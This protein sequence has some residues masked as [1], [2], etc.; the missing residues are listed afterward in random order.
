LSVVANAAAAADQFT[1]LTVREIAKAPSARLSPDRSKGWLRRSLPLVWAHKLTLGF[2]LGLST[3]SVALQA[4]LLLISRHTIDYAI[5]LRTASLE[6]WV[7]LLVLVA[8]L[9]FIVSLLGRQLLFVTGFG[10][11]YDLRSIVFEHLQRLPYEFHVR[12]QTGQLMSRAN[13]DIRVV[14]A[15]LTFGPSI[16]ISLLGAVFYFAVMITISPLL[17]AVALF[18]IPLVYWA[19]V[20]MRRLMF[21]ISWL[22][23]ARA[24]D[25]STVVEENIGGV[26]VVKAFAAESYQL[27]NLALAARKLQWAGIQQVDIQ[28]RWSPVLQALPALSLAGVLLLGGWMVIHHQVSIGTLVAFNGYVLLMQAPFRM[29]GFILAM[30]QMASAS[31]H[32][33]YEVLDTPPAIVDKAGAAPLVVTLPEVRFRGVG[34]RYDPELPEI[35]SGLDL[36]IAPG[37]TLALVGAT[38]SGKSTA[39]RLLNRTLDVTDGAVEIDRVDVRDVTLSSL[40]RTVGMVLDEPF[41]FSASIL[42]NIAYGQPDAGFEDIVAAAKAAGAHDFISE[43]PG[44]YDAVVGER[45]YTLSGGQRQRIAIAR[46]LLLDPKVLVLDDATSAID[47]HVEL[48][49]HRALRK[50]LGQ[51]T[52]LVVAHRLSTLALADRVAL[53]DEGRV[54]AQGSHADLLVSEPRYAAILARVQEEGAAHA[55]ENAEAPKRPAVVA[56]VEVRELNPD[57]IGGGS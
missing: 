29:L 3:L 11:E 20:R 51:R 10:I 25:V 4:G 8:V 46:V 32:R 33:I 12:N 56:D 17:T 15:F 18:T 44:G 38:G 31:A 37:E 36:T 2:A 6:A 28:A 30:G 19:G 45:G 5:T 16:A 54:V 57:L 23:Q 27:R 21:P 1:P 9:L 22:V 35:L 50:L 43:L 41:L 47:V 24:G 55:E 48:E 49:I 53:L 39:A 14:Q 52:T 7:A 42:E 26:R 40:R 13:S 34:Y